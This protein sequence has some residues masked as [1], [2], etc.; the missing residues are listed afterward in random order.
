[1]TTC[2]NKMVKTKLIT[3]NNDYNDDN[4]DDKYYPHLKTEEQFTNIQMNH[5]SKKKKK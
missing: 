2:L 4:N 5:L 1:M 3:N